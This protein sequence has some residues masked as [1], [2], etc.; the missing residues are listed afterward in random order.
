MHSRYNKVT[1]RRAFSSVAPAQRFEEKDDLHR[2]SHYA[3]IPERGV[4][5]IEGPDTAKFLQGLTTNHMPLIAAGGDG[6][7]TAF[8]TPQVSTSYYGILY[9]ACVN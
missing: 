6:F 9:E 5:E 1:I 7:F 3:R 4:L 2:G 8:L